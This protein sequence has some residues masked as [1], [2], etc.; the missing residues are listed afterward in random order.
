MDVL[1]AIHDCA[2]GIS[3]VTSYSGVNIH[4]AE[5]WFMAAY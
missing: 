3:L 2:L 4:R 5:L 1:Y